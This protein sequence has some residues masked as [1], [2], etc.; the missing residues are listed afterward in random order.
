VAANGTFLIVVSV[1][2]P[3]GTAN[4]VVDTV[5]VTGTSSV[6][7]FAFDTAL[8][9]TTVNAPNVSVVK[10]VLPAGPQPPFTVLTYTIV[11]TN[12]GL[13][14]AA[15]VVVTDPIPGFTTYVTGSMSLNGGGLTD[16][17]LDDAGDFDVTTP[18]AITVSIGTLVPG[19]SATVTFQ[20]TIN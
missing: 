6:A 18:G 5:T 12:N 10:S 2:V 9:T 17:S 3:A 14:D 20:V 15:A 1:A 16:G 19:G 4:A 7:P 8:D 11:V 13:S